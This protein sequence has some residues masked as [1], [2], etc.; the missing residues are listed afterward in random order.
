MAIKKRRQLFNEKKNRY[1]IPLESNMSYTPKRELCLI[2]NLAL[3]NLGIY[4]YY[5]VLLGL[6]ASKT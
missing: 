3:F 1:D 5:K 6:I 4:L 2:I